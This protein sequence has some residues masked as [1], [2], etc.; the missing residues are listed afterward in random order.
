MQATNTAAVYRAL[1]RAYPH[2][3]ARTALTY[4]S[5]Y[6]LVVAVILSAQCTDARVNA[7]TPAFFARF[8]DPAAL[9]RASQ[10]QVEAL[11]H[12]VGLYH[13]KARALIGM[14]HA[15][16]ESHAD[17]PPPDRTAL[18]KLP[19]VGRKSANV[20]LSVL[21]DVPALAVDTHVGRVA[22]R[23]G[24][25]DST[26]PDLIERDVTARFPAARWNLLH[27]LL[28]THGRS[29]CHARSPRCPQCTVRS[30]CRYALAATER[31]RA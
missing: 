21:Y 15:L 31:R 19:G 10:R 20:I 23:L 17:I 25:S 24:W 12:S 26:R 13:N 3:V 9:A 30:W 18:M 1:R 5:P 14:A 16:H 29:I 22:Q 7:V 4:R 27:R 8:S 11:I 28:I 6:E 2:V